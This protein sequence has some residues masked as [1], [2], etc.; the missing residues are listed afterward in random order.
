VTS[1]TAPTAAPEP[2]GGGLRFAGLDGLRAVA[3]CSVLVY[4]V[5]AVHAA[6]AAHSLGMLTA[7]VAPLSEGVTLFFCLSGF[8]LYR[9]FAAALINGTRPPSIRR[10]AAKRMRRIAPAY[11]AVLLLSTLMVGHAGYF[12]DLHKL[13]LL[14]RQALLVA[15]YS[16]ST[17]WSGLTPSWTLAI[18]LV[19]YLALPLTAAWAL[20][21]RQRG[22]P[23]IAAAC[24]PPA[25]FLAIGVIGKV[26][27]TIIGGG[28]EDTNAY[29][30]H[31]VL[32]ASFLTHADL[33]TYGM[34]VAIVHVLATNGSI[35]LPAWLDGAMTRSL[36]YL[37]IPFTLLGYYLVPHYIYHPIVAIFASQLIA[38]LVLPRTRTAPSLLQRT[39]EHRAV[40]YLGAISYSIFLW[41]STVIGFLVKH[42]LFAGTS[43]APGLLADTAIV[44]AIT[45]TLSALT[46]EYVE[47]PFLHPG[48]RS[49]PPWATLPADLF[50]R[51]RARQP[52][53]APE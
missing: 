37:G 26:L 12:V 48:R 8:L 13:A 36:L 32:D 25:A 39:L 6:A 18:E 11:W 45:L 46:Y 17:I 15:N 9:P 47:R 41:N 40:V 21:R 22:R 33:F 4:H 29:T 19:F 27:V 38:K 51:L 23:A 5:W 50:R 3:A 35:T 31:A 44:A 53:P 34:A 43:T 20:A 24:L 42:G 28:G 16:P 10:Y 7:A 52:V 1:A 14:G 30:V 49:A 2:G